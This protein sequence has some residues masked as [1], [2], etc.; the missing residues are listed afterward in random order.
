MPHALLCSASADNARPCQA[1]C[2]KRRGIEVDSNDG[3]T[4]DDGAAPSTLRS[5][6]SSPTTHAQSRERSPLSSLTHS[7]L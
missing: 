7:A 6:A 5:A 3:Y 1:G 4:G 2:T